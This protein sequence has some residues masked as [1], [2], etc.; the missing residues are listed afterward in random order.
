MSVKTEILE[1]CSTVTKIEYTSK[2]VYRMTT[3][4]DN[5]IPL[6]LAKTLQ[7]INIKP[8]DSNHKSKV[9]YHNKGKTIKV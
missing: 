6:E 3:T 8:T 2:G 5:L 7:L 9:P 1:T 4:F